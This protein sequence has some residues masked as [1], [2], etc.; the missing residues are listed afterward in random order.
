MTININLEEMKEIGK[1]EDKIKN[2][3]QDINSVL[4]KKVKLNI[5]ALE[6]GEKIE[7]LQMQ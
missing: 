7:I 5:K 3:R 2:D 4:R 1:P 6:P